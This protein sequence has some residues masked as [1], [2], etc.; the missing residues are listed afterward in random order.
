MGNYNFREEG[1]AAKAR[2]YL[3]KL[4][5]K[6]SRGKIEETNTRTS[7]QNAA[8]HL[9][10]TI[11]SNVLNEGGATY[12]YHGI[13]GRQ[14]DTMYT[15]TIVKEFI[16]K[17]IQWELFQIMSTT[18]LDTQKINAITD[19]LVLAFGNEGVKLE[20]PNI[21]TLMNKNNEKYTD[22]ENQA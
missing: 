11:I 12:T 8:L 7:K 2:K 10:Y 1:H 14:F 19:V 15:T 6:G 21:E 17:P 3:E 18:K 16:W 20:F 4:I 5:A 13:K 9:F 22:I